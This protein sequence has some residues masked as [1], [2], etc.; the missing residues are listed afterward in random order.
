MLRK[1]YLTLIYILLYLPIAILVLYSFNDAR[2]SLTWH[3]FS[4]RWYRELLHD[5]DLWIA[6][7][8]SLFLGVSASLIACGLGLI[9]S[10]HF[11]IHKNA[12]KLTLNTLL[13]L[14]VILPDLVLGVSLLVFFN[15]VQIPLGFWS[16]LIAH[17]TFCIPFTVI[18]L[19]SR[20]HHLDVNIYF[21]AL[22]LGATHREALQKILFPLL[23]PALLSA[24]LL[25]FTL[26]FDDVII[27]YFVAGPD[28]NI[29]PLTIY[30]LV[31][32]GVTPELN[33]L[34]SITLLL[35]IPLV[36]ISHYFSRET[37]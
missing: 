18:T 30:S 22:D 31:R 24:F 33:A 7:V 32:A 11:F 23:W 28:F 27:S 1:S 19:N 10:V 5:T 36:M 12:Q 34:C 20:I 13:L 8:H 15:Y 9:V 16:L 17:I 4:L 25:G 14:L 37:V 26:S 2:F 35:S 3:G 6:F 29:L 21:S